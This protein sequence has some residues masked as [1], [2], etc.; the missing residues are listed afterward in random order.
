MKFT[1]SWLRELVDVPVSFEE[2]TG[3][4]TMAGLEVESVT[5]CLP[6][7]SD[8][9]IARVENI[10]PLTDS[11]TLKVCV[12]DAGSVAKL[13]V[14]CGAPDVKVGHCYPL[15]RPGATLPGNR[16]IQITTIQGRVS[17]GM[18]CSGRELGLSEDD[19]GLFELPQDASPGSSLAEYLMLNDVLVEISL[20]PNR[21]DCLGM[22]G[23]AREVAV[24]NNLDYSPAK[25]IP[26]SNTIADS[27]PIRI[28]ASN[29]CPRYCGRIIR[30]IDMNA[31]VPVM[32]SERLRRAGIR[33]INP[34]VDLTNYVMLETGQP[35]HAFDNDALQGVLHIRQARQDEPVVLL[36]GSKR[37]LTENTLVIADDSGAVAMAGIMGGQLS[38]VNNSSTTIFLESA[39]FDPQAIMGRAR[40]YGLHTEASHR[41]ERGVDPDMAA[42]AMERL[43]QLIL[44]TCKGE[45]GPV[46]EV[47]N[48]DTL[49]PIK[50]VQL[51]A[52][53]VRKLLGSQISDQRISLL[54]DKLGFGL[55]QTTTG[56]WQVQVPSY[57]F[58]ISLE[59]DLIEEVARIDGYKNIFGTAPALK[60]RMST[61]DYSRQVIQD[62]SAKLVARGYRESISYSFIDPEIQKYFVTTADKATLLNPISIEM[63]ELRQSLWPGLIQALLYNV[64][65]QQTTVRLFE[66]GKVYLGKEGTDEVRMI[67]GI[68]YGNKHNKQWGILDTS[69]DLYDIKSD[70]ETIIDGLSLEVTFSKSSDYALHPG[71]TAEVFS[72][73]TRV[74]VLG[75][76]HP[77]LIKQ[78]SLNQSVYLFQLELDKIS[79]IKTLKFSK[80]SKYPSIRRD[81]SIV[82]DEALESS[83]ILNVVKTASSEVLVNLELFDVYRGKGID[84]GKKS[85][86]LGLT[87]QR[88]SSTLTDGEAD[89]VVGNILQSLHKHFGAIL[90]E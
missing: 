76:L 24:L 45:P 73:K 2:L 80:I 42:V 34:V 88:S 51:R 6:E 33:S 85:L 56:I 67:G 43:T 86:A 8:V 53:R 30:G 27:R 44:S 81:I 70:V 12:L 22:T 38:A 28:D 54:L 14:V 21:G 4:L 48:T 75:M 83:S 89:E 36:D 74:G 18:L 68:I 5:S 87:F 79:S 13:T 26:V 40:Q 71:Q 39:Y 84:L 52:D 90:R 1:E 82:V 59:V 58:D 9:I 46:T 20:T 72:G 32:I 7:F 47:S 25:I 62:I 37:N 66:M 11:S 31:C 63:S 15:A 78:F 35:M 64:N 10:E 29:A 23:L 77:A 69:V 17:E 60:M 55:T 57:R 3:Q 19:S 49:P 50:T 41:F 65:R 16:S 61:P